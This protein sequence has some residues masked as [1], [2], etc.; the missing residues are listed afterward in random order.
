MD[1]AGPI[2]GIGTRGYAG[3]ENSH[4]FAACHASSDLAGDSIYPKLKVIQVRVAKPSGPP[5]V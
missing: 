5:Y 1:L 3:F 2:T 4:G